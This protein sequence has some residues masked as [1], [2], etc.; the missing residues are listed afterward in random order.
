MWK[1]KRKGGEG[2]GGQPPGRDWGGRNIISF[3]FSVPFLPKSFSPLLGVG[4]EWPA[5]EART[6]VFKDFIKLAGGFH[7]DMATVAGRLFRFLMNHKE[8]VGTLVITY[9]VK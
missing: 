7:F 4:F 5:E 9:G 3:L 1:R 2:G 6:W 8:N